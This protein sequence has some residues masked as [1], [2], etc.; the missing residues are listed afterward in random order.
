MHPLFILAFATLFAVVAFG[1][2]NLIS[3]RRN[4]KTGGDV[5]GLGGPADPMSGTTTNR[6]RSGEEIRASLNAATARQAGLRPVTN[7]APG[8]VR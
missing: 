1:A 2:W 8:T 4:Q 5:S 6:I 7:P 3:T